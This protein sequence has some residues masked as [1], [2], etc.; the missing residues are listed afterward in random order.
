MSKPGNIKVFV[1]GLRGFPGVQGGVEKHCEELYPRLVRMGCEVIVATRSPYIP[2]ARQVKE[3]K[4]VKFLHLP[5]LKN[6]YLEAITH[7]LLGVMV[8]RMHSPDILHIHAIGPSILTPMVKALGLR[9]VVTH[10]GPDYL[11]K[12]WGRFARIVLTAGETMACKFADGVIVISKTVRGML[13]NKYGR[14]DLEFIPNGV[15]FPGV[16]PPGETLRKYRLQ[17]GEYVFTASRFVPEKG[18][19]DSIAAYRKVKKPDFK[20]VIAGDADHEDVWSRKI[21]RTARKDGRIIL[22]GALFG[23]PLEELYS[24]AG[25]FVLPSYHEGLPIALL[26]A[27]SY[28]LPVLASDIPANLEV[29]LPHHRYFPVGDVD[30]LSERMV[31]LFRQGISGEES[32]KQ[33]ALLKKNY[34]W[35][36][37]AE[38]TRELYRNILRQAG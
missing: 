35:D 30:R 14:R 21:K 18:L 28:R 15:N 17:P 11:R 19:H 24:N 10:H 3:W 9:V 29:E 34:N 33:R 32:R 26:E 13:V 8:A 2:K 5:A 27:M 22:T 31:A 23:E 37:I 6:K 16:L 4:G 20:L 1:L 38:R 25:L 7:S 12:K 36:R